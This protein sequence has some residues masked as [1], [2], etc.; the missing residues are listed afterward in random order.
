[1]PSLG[2]SLPEAVRRTDPRVMRAGELALLPL[3]ALQRAGPESPLGSIVA[4]AL[5]EGAR[6]NSTPHPPP[7]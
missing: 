4:L 2:P 3:A 5:V 1:M 7:G 6:V